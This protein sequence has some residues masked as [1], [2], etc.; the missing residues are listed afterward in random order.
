MTTASF[1]PIFRLPGAA[2]QAHMGSSVAAFHLTGQDSGGALGLF[3]ITLSPGAPGAGPHLHQVLAEAF[4]VLS[5]VVRLQLGD[6]TADAPAGSFMF[7]PPFTPHA[8][9]NPGDAPARVL[10]IFTEPGRREEFFTGLAAYAGR[11]ERPSP[12]EAAAFYARHDQYPAPFTGEQ[13][14]S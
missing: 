5:G 11:T 9:S 12:Q 13:P 10:L 3:E 1:A 7:V 14:R 2:P 4:Y 6:Q 8:F